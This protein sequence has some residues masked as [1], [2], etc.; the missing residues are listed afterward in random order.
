MSLSLLFI[1]A[2]T[3]PV[4]MAV[5]GLHVPHDESSVQEVNNL[6]IIG[7]SVVRDGAAVGGRVRRNTLRLTVLSSLLI[8]LAVAFLVMHCFIALK[9]RTAKHESTSHA[10]RLALDGNEDCRVSIRTKPTTPVM[11]CLEHIGLLCM[12]DG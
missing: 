11:G 7:P 10:R 4:G 8:S 2:S 6:A 12:N 9:S 1:F 5:S 3:L